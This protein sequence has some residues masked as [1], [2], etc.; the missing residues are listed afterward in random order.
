MGVSILVCVPGLEGTMKLKTSEAL[1]NAIE[2]LTAECGDQVETIKH[3]YP[4]GYSIARARN[5]MAQWAL[6]AKAD[7]L[8]M[9]D[10]DIILPQDA[11]ANLLEHREK[12]CIGWYARGSDEHRTNIVRLNTAGHGDCYSVRE[13][14][15]M[16]YEGPF[17]VK[18]GGM[19]CALISTEVFGRFRRPWFEYLDSENGNGTSEDYMFCKKC[20]EAG[21]SIMLDPRVG[22][23]HIKERVLE[24][25]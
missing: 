19:G 12:A 18:A 3:R 10:S 16:E 6:E 20:W 5:F 1:G 11:I 2:Y 22:C 21:V 24:A 7:Y 25:R 14:A 15:S 23:G 13:L 17:E 4:I 8:L 9:V